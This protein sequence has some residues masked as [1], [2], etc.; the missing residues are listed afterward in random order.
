TIHRLLTDKKVHIYGGNQTRDFIF[1]KDIATAC[2]LALVTNT[3]GVFNI[4][5]GTETKIDELF[6]Q[7]S[8]V[9]G[10][11]D[12]VPVY[13][14][15]RIGEIQNSV[16][17]NRKAIKEFDWHPRYSLA[18]GLQETIHYYSNTLNFEIRKSNLL[19]LKKELFI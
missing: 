11:P 16:L 18:K 9:S 14:P 13:K 6:Y 12:V 19:D 10:R 2:C 4:S 5:S 17:D 1:V 8:K 3:R 15:V 7:V